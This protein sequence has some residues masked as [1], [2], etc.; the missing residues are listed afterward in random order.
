MKIMCNDCYEGSLGSS[1]C[2]IKMYL[3]RLRDVGIHRECV[4]D[5]CLVKMMCRTLCKEFRDFYSVI[6]KEANTYL[7]K[8]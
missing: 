1:K 8:N 7:K 6:L 3:E 4:C 5:D 2:N